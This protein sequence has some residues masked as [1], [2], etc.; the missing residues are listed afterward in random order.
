[1]R[2]DKN[3]YVF[4]SDYRRYGK[5][6]RFR[7]TVLV[8]IPLLIL[9]FFAANFTISNRIRMEDLRLT[10]LNL[11]VDLEEYS[12]LHISDLH[13]ARYGE[14]QKA[15]RNVLGTA[16]YSCVVMTGDMLGENGDVEP[17][18]ELIDLM[19]KDTPKYLIPGDMDSPLVDTG[20]HGSLSP[21]ADWA[22][23]VQQAG[24]TL[25]DRPVSETRDKGTIWFIP[26]E[27]YTLDVDVTESVYKKQLSALKEK[28]DSL[29][30]DEAAR[31]R[32]LEYELQ[33]MEELR[34]TKAEIKP[35]DIQ[36]VLTHTPLTEDF[37]KSMLSWTD[38]ESVFSVRYASLIL[39]GH[40]NGG[41][42]R[43][44]GKGAVYVPEFGWF[45]EDSK[46]QGLSYLN[47]IPQYIS[48]GLGSDPHYEYQPGRLFN[49]P[50]ITRIFLTRKDTRRQ[51]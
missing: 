26:D 28:G 11:P 18:L 42:W 19:P 40:Y 45:P 4:A 8:L 39:A 6:H 17:L 3:K 2:R 15:I 21:Y 38:K 49:A 29:T 12:I 1:M 33:R 5:T 41:Q 25:L 43:I 32:A 51:E 37:V 7:N 35:T 30:A 47:G 20:A 48:P 34:A 44:P 22:L 23:R 14:K 36:I 9:V 13:G 10:V 27:V 16:R 46:I 50:Q 24:V 31:V